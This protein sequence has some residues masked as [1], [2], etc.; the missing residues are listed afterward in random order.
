MNNPPRIFNRPAVWSVQKSGDRVTDGTKPTIQHF[1]GLKTSILKDFDRICEGAEELAAEQRT[2][3][4]L[5][6]GQVNRALFEGERTNR[7]VEALSAKID[8]LDRK[9]SE[10]FW[11]REVTGVGNGDDHRVIPPTAAASPRTRSLSLNRGANPQQPYTPVVAR[12]QVTPYHASS[13]NSELLEDLDNPEASVNGTPQHFLAAEEDNESIL[14]ADLNDTR[15]YEVYVS[16]PNNMEENQASSGNTVALTASNGTTPSGGTPHDDVNNVSGASAGAKAPSDEEEQGD[17]VVDDSNTGNRED[18]EDFVPQVMVLSFKS[19]APLEMYGGTTREDFNGFVRAFND[20]IL[21]MEAEATDEDKKRAFL[22]VLK[23]QARDRA[24]SILTERPNA[25]FDYIIQGMKEMFVGTSHIQRSK[26]LLRSSKQAPGESADVFFHRISKL[27]RQSYSDN[28]TFQKEVTLEQFL[29][30]L[31]PSVKTLVML[32][33]PTTPEEALG[34]ALSVEGC[35]TPADQSTS[36]AQIPE[37]LASLTSMVID[38]QK[39]NNQRD[40]ARNNRERNYSRDGSSSS[41]GKCFYCQKS[42]HYV[43]ECRKK[44]SDQAN[45]IS[46]QRPN[47]SRNPVDNHRVDNRPRTNTVSL[48]NEVQALR[49]A[50]KARD[51]QLEEYQKR[52]DRTIP[53]GYYSGSNASVSMIY[54]PT[55]VTEQNPQVQQA[56]FNQHRIGSER[57]TAQVPIKA[58]G[59]KCNALFDTGSNITIAGDN[60]RKILR[61]EQLTKTP[62]E[63]ACGLGGNQVKMAGYADITFQI[64]S[65]SITQRTY[66]TTGRCTPGNPRGY[67][68]IFGN[69]LLSRLPM[70]IFDYAN[71]SLHIGKD[72]LPLGTNPP[73]TPSPSQFDI[74]VAEETVISPRSERIVKCTIPE[75][76]SRTSELTILAVPPRLPS[77]CLFVAPTVMSSNNIAVMITNASEEEV[78][79]QSKTKVARGSQLEED[80]EFRIDLTKAEGI[81]VEEKAALQA[82]LDTYKDVFS[83][84]AYDLGSSKTDPVHIYTNTEVPVRGRP[85]RVPVKYQ[86]ELEK[87]INGLLLS[88]RI[89]ESNTPWTSP[90]VLVKKKNGSLRVCLDFRKLNEVTIPDNYPLPRIDTIIEKVGNARYFSSL[91]MA[92]GYL[93]LRLDAESSYK[94]GFITENKVYAYTHL[95]FGLKS[96]AS[97]FQRALKTVLA[98]LEEDVMVYIDDVLIYSKTF[99]EHLVTLRHVLSRFRQFS[100]KASPKKCEFVKQSIVF[101][102][103]EISGTSYSPNQANVDSIERLPTPNNVPELKRFIGMAGFFRKFIENFA[104][105]AE[106]LTR[107]TRKEQKF[108][109]SE[110]Q[111]EAWMKLKT[112]LTSKPILS[113]PNYEK[114]F[115]IFTDASSVAQGAVL[116]QATDTDP[117]NFHVIAYVSRT[118]SDEETRW[119]AIQIELGAIIFALRQFKP[120]VCLSKI[121]LHSDHR[122]L[123]FLLA[124]NKVNDNLARWLVELQQYDIEIVHIEGKKNTVADCLS[125][126]KDEIAPLNNQEMEDII[127]FPIC[128]SNRPRR[129]TESRVLTVTGSSKPINLIT[130]QDM[131]KDISIIKRFLKNPATP[132]DRL[133]DEW[134]DVLDLMQI[135]AKGFLVVVFE[136]TP[137]TVIPRQLRSLIFDSFHTNVMAGGHLNFR[138]SHQKARRKFFW[139][140][141][142]SDFFRWYS[143]CVP[144]QQKRHPHPSTRQPQSVVITTRIFEKVGVDLAG[145]LKTTT[146]LHKYYI[147]IICW[148]SKFVI[149]VPLPDATAE[150]VARVILEECV[151]KYGTPTEIVSDNGPCF[152]AAAFKQFCTMLSIGHHLAIPH[153][154]RGNGATERT[155]RTFHQ[156]TSKYVNPT[157]TN[158]DTILPCVTFAYNTAVHSTTGET[159][160]YLMFGR[161][162]TFVIDKILDPSPSGFT[163]EDVR[164][165]ATHI[166]TTLRQAWKDAAEHSLKVQ[167][168]IQARANDGAKGSDIQPGDR[169]LMKNYE[170]K[171]G[172]SRK[173]VLPWVG[174]YRVLEVSENEALIQNLK[175]PD[176]APKRVHL[177]QIKK[178]ILP[179]ATDVRAEPESTVEVKKMFGKTSTKPK[180]VKITEDVVK[181]SGTGGQAEPTPTQPPVGRR[182]PPRMRNPPKRLG[183]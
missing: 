136:G 160:F 100:L 53:D 50:I 107:L 74:K 118:L 52:H 168:Q 139:P 25:T 126:A 102:G 48:E 80:P 11:N 72:I 131:D 54:W 75:E 29:N 22:T 108:V 94:C 140:N 182:N 144:C 175:K 183:G 44:R 88:N 20:R 21:A 124:K 114:P 158:W 69:D 180:S 7:L 55:P 173:L 51:D 142:K 154:S 113:F 170:S 148:F 155:F 120:Y 30:G 162:P 106:P 112:A 181:P 153:H 18:E 77:E 13:N 39:Q 172:L 70:F 95:P 67:D 57:I 49:S 61:I 36:M 163:D 66:F 37:L 121:V 130:E 147:N 143:E 149:S 4:Q 19:A 129:P 178:L 78:T 17:D 116:M 109:W 16:T 145:P 167:E 161:D 125:R 5:V 14:H 82:L 28:A 166:T 63:H 171:A 35:V 26:A 2:N 71:A 92:N 156:M 31:N 84:N 133:P 15:R 105:I 59:F 43:R 12:H 10:G 38:L 68:F 33:A 165:W 128:M 85:Y 6:Q 98:G 122:P 101:L 159:P 46:G 93:Q 42:G 76:I 27:A 104:G 40:D 32:R 157:H 99:E 152:S 58:N 34:Y 179:A 103:H 151:L 3:L 123:T 174:D 176:K 73:A 1:L 60:T 45:G 119:T 24:E 79:L 110:E 87:H 9:V 117:R 138:K 146:R 177:D 47:R 115:H 90:I 132:I 96:A 56:V 137:R 41:Q 62:F 91:D 86:A 134:S 89:T 97:Y 141:M 164:D 169:V 65:L 64:G 23:D 127:D 8:E 135:S 111:Q 83:K 81:S 150:T